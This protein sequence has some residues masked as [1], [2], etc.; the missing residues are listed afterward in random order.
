MPFVYKASFAGY[1][2]LVLYFL[3]RPNHSF[4]SGIN[5]AVKK[6]DD[7]IIFSLRSHLPF[8]HDAHSLFSL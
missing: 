6:S 5:L 1:K 3:E 2:I 8:L 4:S 7:N